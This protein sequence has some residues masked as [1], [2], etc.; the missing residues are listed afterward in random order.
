[1]MDEKLEK[2]IRSHR[3]EMDNREPGSQLWGKIAQ[4]M[5]DES[6]QR[7]IGTSFIW[8]R[9]AAVFLLLISAALVVDRFIG[10][11]AS[12]QVVANEQIKEAENYYMSLISSKQQH[13]VAMSADLNLGVDFTNELETLDSMYVL[14]KQDLTTGNEESLTDAMILNLQMRIEPAEQAAGNYPG[15]TKPKNAKFEENETIEL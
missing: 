8:W 11:F 13:I 14:L 12:Q 5:S 10:Q 4:Q 2:F 6:K 15:N 7:E 3:A 9:A 1:M